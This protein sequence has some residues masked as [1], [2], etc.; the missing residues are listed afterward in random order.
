MMDYEDFDRIYH[1]LGRPNDPLKPSFRNHFVISL[2]SE[3]AQGFQTSPNWEL[4]MTIND[5]QDGVFRVTDEGRIALSA[6]IS[7][8]EKSDAV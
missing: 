5:N 8:R 6:W 1:A 7:R 3:I 2:D 4:S